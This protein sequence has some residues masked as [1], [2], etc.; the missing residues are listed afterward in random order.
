MNETDLIVRLQLIGCKYG[1]MFNTQVNDLKWG[2][3]CAK[4]NLWNLFILNMYLEILECHELD[5][6]D[7]CFTQ[8]QIDVIFDNISLITGL[9]FK[10][11]G[12]TYAP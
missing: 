2:R 1:S 9:C 8:A 12:Y 10:P 3:K 6:D 11:Y 7:S 4:K 5:N